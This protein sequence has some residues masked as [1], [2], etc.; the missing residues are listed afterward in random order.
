MSSATDGCSVDLSDDGLMPLTVSVIATV[1]ANQRSACRPA[2]TVSA[3]VPDLVV[4]QG[5]R[6]DP[7]DTV[8]EHTE[9]L[10]AA[11]S[12]SYRGK[13]LGIWLCKS[14]GPGP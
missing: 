10:A 8:A 1:S 3:T 13:A 12:V 5:M 2:Y 14:L 9:I 11:G 7:D 4:L 6:D